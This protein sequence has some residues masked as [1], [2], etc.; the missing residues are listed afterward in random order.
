MFLLKNRKF[1]GASVAVT[2][3]AAAWEWGDIFGILDADDSYKPNKVEK[4]VE[5]LME[6]QEIGVAYGDYDIH[7]ELE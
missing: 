1:K 5:K 7:K 6:H 2:A 3:L 4:L